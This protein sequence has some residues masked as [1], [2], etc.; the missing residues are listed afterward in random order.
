[1]GQNLENIM[2][3]EPTT[4]TAPEPEVITSWRQLNPIRVVDRSD[5][6]RKGLYI[7]CDRI[8]LN[9]L[10]LERLIATLDDYGTAKID[11]AGT[12]E[13]IPKDE[14]ETDEI[15]GDV[16]DLVRPRV[17]FQAVAWLT[18]DDKGT[19]TK[20]NICLDQ[21]VTRSSLNRVAEDAIARTDHVSRVVLEH[22]RQTLAVGFNRYG[23]AY[24]TRAQMVLE[25]L[26]RRMGIEIESAI[27][28]EPLTSPL[29]SPTQI[30]DWMRLM[31]VFAALMAFD[32]T[33]G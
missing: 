23:A 1:M 29:M 15:I 20:G 26:A 21:S 8:G 11:D 25:R 18:V 14:Y 30:A 24:A 32:H 3:T 6:G 27:T 9:Q 31:P 22:D 2:A 7:A 13:L 16:R 33:R 10:N 5:D 12:I 28:T 17:T 19:V 4:D